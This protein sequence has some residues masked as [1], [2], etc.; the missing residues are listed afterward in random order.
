[1]SKESSDSRPASE[2]NAI[3]TM[4]ATEPQRTNPN[5]NV[6]GKSKTVNSSKPIRRVSMGEILHIKPLTDRVSGL[7]YMGQSLQITFTAEFSE[8]SNL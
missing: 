6:F 1:M 2:V 7:L 8:N 5:P 3:L 4:N